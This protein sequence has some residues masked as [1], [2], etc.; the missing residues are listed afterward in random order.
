MSETFW[1]ITTSMPEITDITAINVAVASII[2]NNVRK[3]RSLLP[4]SD[5]TAPTTAS[6]KEA[7]DVI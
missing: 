5:W 3:L 4:R 6:Q 2:P 1:A 7:C